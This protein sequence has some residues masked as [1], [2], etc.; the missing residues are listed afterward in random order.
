MNNKTEGFGNN[1]RALREDRNIKQYEL[2]EMLGMSTPSISY[3]ENKGSKPKSKETI[4]TLCDFFGVTETD[5]L[6]YSDGY[7]AKTRLGSQP[8]RI[9]KPVAA[10]AS[11]PVVGAAHAGEPQPAYEV[12][13]GTIP[14]PEEYAR[15]GNFFIQIAGD[16]MN[17]V[18]TE[19][20]YALI[21]THGEVQSGDVALVKV[22]GDDATVKRV[23]LMDGVVFLEPDSSNPSHKRRVIDAADPES[24]EVRLLGRVVYAVVRF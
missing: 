13:L 24:P 18:L 11:L 1:I 12:D 23:R 19:G 4:K 6:G 22:N 15:D 5:L 16:S 21:D 10:T 20:T 3:W 14:C 7:Y 8:P 2:A 17:N 9:A